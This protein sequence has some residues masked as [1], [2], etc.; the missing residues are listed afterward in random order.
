VALP[1]L[2]I[3]GSAYW[4]YR[5]SFGASLPRAYFED[6]LVSR[7][8]DLLAL[9]L[10][11]VLGTVLYPLLLRKAPNLLAW[12]LQVAV[13]PEALAAVFMAFGSSTLYD[14]PFFIAHALKVV[15]GLAPLGGIC[16]HLVRS[17]R[18][19]MKAADSMERLVAEL[20]S[21][22]AD[23]RSKE[24]RLDQLTN[25][26]KEVFWLS[27]PDG[28]GMHYVSPAYEEI[29]GLSCEELYRDPS[30]FLDVVHPEDRERM[31]EIL[32]RSPARD[33]EI[34][35]RILRSNGELRWLRTRGFPFRGESGD[36]YRVAGITED[37][38]GR[39]Q[40]EN[41]LR[42]SEARTR[43]LLRAMPDLMFRMSR[44]GTILDY[45]A[46]PAARLYKPPS[47]FLG[48]R[49][50]DVIPELGDEFLRQIEETL[51]TG[52]VQS[53]GYRLDCDGH[54]GE[55]EARFAPSDDEVLVVIRDVTEQSR[56][57][58][59]ILDVSHREQERIGHDLH[60][61]ISQRLTGIALLTKA[62]QQ[63]LTGKLEAEASRAAQIAML[64][65]ETLTQ[66]KSLAR[67]LAP[68]ELE[69]GG[70]SAALEDLA[71]GVEMIHRVRCHFRRQGDVDV[72]DR[73]TAIHVFRIAQEAVSNALRHGHPGRIAIELTA[74]RERERLSVSDDGRGIGTGGARPMSGMGLHIMRYRSRMIEGALDVR[75]GPE[76][77]TIVTCEWPR[78][79][80]VPSN[81]APVRRR[82][83][84]S[85]P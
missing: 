39:K 41:E 63:R 13:L 27:S 73:A 54:V 82:T 22:E 75:P 72:H 78:F 47:E 48:A 74:T 49:M 43:A 15:G 7:P 61:G 21:V 24:V 38:T 85:N 62:L 19:E 16:L 28:G 25:N 83:A 14:R 68:V 31:V 64:V 67:G 20:K 58:R 37:V 84:K 56:L 66:T 23:L 42:K 50:G 57:Q 40:T 33:F 77:G 36:V 3:A 2:G 26:I 11:L 8:W 5:V 79:S 53:M 32:T 46:T 18:R 30:S 76:R 10:F 9:P 4:F 69:G 12:A 35:Y 55:Y 59:E 60:D 52:V 29:F 51:R 71:H 45:H 1:L 6:D 44:S 81:R 34:D 65:D 80:E 70:L 17:Y